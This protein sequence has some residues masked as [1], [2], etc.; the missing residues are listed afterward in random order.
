M[1]IDGLQTRGIFCCSCEIG[2]NSIAVGWLW[3]R[4]RELLG[5]TLS[6]A[7]SDNAEGDRYTVEIPASLP[8]SPT[9]NVVL[10]RVA[11]V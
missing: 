3:W 2:E 4:D 1:K 8:E 10:T 11:A 7:Q 6:L 9:Q 5:R